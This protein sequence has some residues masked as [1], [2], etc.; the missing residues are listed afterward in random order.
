MVKLPVKPDDLLIELSRDDLNYL[1]H[2]YRPSGGPLI[3]RVSN[4]RIRIKPEGAESRNRNLAALNPTP[5]KE[6]AI[7]RYP[8]TQSET[9][10]YQGCDIEIDG[11]YSSRQF[12][13]STKEEIIARLEERHGSL[14]G[15]DLVWVEREYREG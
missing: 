2:R 10:Y 12:N 7:I 3:K 4:V 6:I 11:K 9:G 8:T 1:L 13:V 14:E 5:A 15:I